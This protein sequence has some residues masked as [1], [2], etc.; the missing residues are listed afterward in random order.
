MLFTGQ[1]CRHLQDTAISSLPPPPLKGNKL[2]RHPAWVNKKGRQKREQD[3]RPQ[4]FRHLEVKKTLLAL[5]FWRVGGGTICTET[6]GETQLDPTCPYLFLSCKHQGSRNLF[7]SWSPS[8]STGFS[9]PYTAV[10]RC[11]RCHMMPSP[12]KPGRTA[13]APPGRGV[14]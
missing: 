1:N 5:S 10:T 14:L 2:R 6:K 13:N 4:V 8:P 12:T 11:P 3:F 9:F 7:V